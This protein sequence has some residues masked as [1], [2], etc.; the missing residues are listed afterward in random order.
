MT[1]ADV[2]VALKY[3]IAAWPRRPVDEAVVDVWHEILEPLDATAC[4]DVVR[5]FCRSQAEEAPTPGQIY[6]ET[7]VEQDRRKPR[8]LLIEELDTPEKRAARRESLRAHWL[9][10]KG[11]DPKAA[12]FMAEALPW[13]R[14]AAAA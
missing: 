7:L 2:L 3:I 10:L 13:L 12:E 4:L 11:E 1:R 14:E 9:K 6:R 5:R 8:P